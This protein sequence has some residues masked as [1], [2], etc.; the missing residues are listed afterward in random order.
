MNA[1]QKRDLIKEVKVG[2]LYDFICVHG[3]EFDKEDLLRIIKEYDWGMYD[4]GRGGLYNRNMEKLAEMF[5]ENIEV[6]E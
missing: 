5:E 1:Q 2:Y 4:L 6:D 3:W